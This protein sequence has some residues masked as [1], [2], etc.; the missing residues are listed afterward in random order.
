MGSEWDG[1]LAEQT[2]NKLSDPAHG[3]HGL[4]TL[5]PCRVRCSA[6]LG[7][8][9]MTPSNIILRSEG[10]PR[11]HLGVALVRVRDCNWRLQE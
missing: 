10:E 7:R 2:V 8:V 9:L 1:E 5:T 4:Q 3:R 6:W 11:K